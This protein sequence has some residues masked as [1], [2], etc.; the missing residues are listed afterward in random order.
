MSL[1][2]ACPTQVSAQVKGY[3]AEAI[4]ILKGRAERA[5][6]ATC[7]QLGDT[8]LRSKWASEHRTRIQKTAPGQTA[9]TP[10]TTEDT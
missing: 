6:G 5:R 10:A 9:I 7:V 1:K 2:E 4:G 3:L 8:L